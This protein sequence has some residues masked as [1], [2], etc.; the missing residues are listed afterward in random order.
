MQEQDMSRQEAND[1]TNE[2][3]DWMSKEMQDDPSLTVGPAENVAL[4]DM[5]VPRY[6]QCEFQ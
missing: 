6:P 1:Y 2:V 3:V 5:N 4:D